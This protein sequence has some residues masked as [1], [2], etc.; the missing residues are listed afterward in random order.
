[1]KAIIDLIL[2]ALVTIF[3][4][5]LSGFTDTWLKVLSHYKGRKIQ[6]LKPFSCSLCMVW[7][8]CLIYAAIV[9]NL[10][11]PVVAFIALLSFLSVPLGQL[12][13]LIREAILK[14]INKLMDLL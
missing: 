6:E 7:W 5:D 11:I 9:G 12:L 13:M 8:V 3:I 10:T 2:V 14:V 1:M 4:V